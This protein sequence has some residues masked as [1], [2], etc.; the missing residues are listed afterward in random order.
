MKR[1]LRRYILLWPGGYNPTTGD[2]VMSAM[3]TLFLGLIAFAIICATKGTVFIFIAAVALPIYLLY[4]LFK[5][6]AS[7]DEDELH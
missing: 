4:R 5:W 7:E 2:L 1:F 3:L 6:A